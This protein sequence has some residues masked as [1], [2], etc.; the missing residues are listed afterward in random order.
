[1]EITI[2][3]LGDNFGEV[4][5]DATASETSTLHNWDT[6]EKLPFNST[7]LKF[8]LYKGYLSPITLAMYFGE[9]GFK[10]TLLYCSKMLGDL[11][12]SEYF[13]NVIVNVE[14]CS[15]PSIS[16]GSL[17]LVIETL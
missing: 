17:K 15:S 16:P 9:S 1:M 5:F 8:S 11:S 13:L 2:N 7:L 4:A 3:P 10:L 6:F 14:Y 12:M